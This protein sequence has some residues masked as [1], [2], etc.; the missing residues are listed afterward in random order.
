MSRVAGPGDYPQ[1]V[2][3]FWLRFAD[4]VEQHGE[5][6][7]QL[8]TLSKAISSPFPMLSKWAVR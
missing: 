5:E 3:V 2:N 4:L 7:A 8:E 1:S 6:L